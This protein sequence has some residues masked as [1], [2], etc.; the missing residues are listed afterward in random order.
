MDDTVDV[1]IP[2]EPEVAAVLAACATV[3]RSVDLSVGFCDPAQVQAHSPR[4]SL[5]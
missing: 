4:Q 1:T 3:R 2:V 5:R